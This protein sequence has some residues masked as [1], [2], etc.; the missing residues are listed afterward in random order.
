MSEALVLLGR[1]VNNLI[2]RVDRRQKPNGPHIR[3]DISK[4]PVNLRKSRNEEKSNQLKEVQCHECEG[5][6]HIRPECPTYLRK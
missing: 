6:G 4:Q 3:F 5:H 2:K 1:P